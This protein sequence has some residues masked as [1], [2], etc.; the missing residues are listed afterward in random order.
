MTIQRLDELKALQ[1]AGA[2]AARVLEAMRR[3]LRPGMTT[4]QVDEIGRELIERHGARSAPQLVYGFPGWSCISLNDEIV[5]GVPGP[6]RLAPGDVVKLDV[7]VEKDGFMADTA[8][9]VQLAPRSSLGARLASCVRAAFRRGLDAARADAPVRRIGRAVE[10]E[11][12][13]H[14]FR[15]VRELSGHGIGRTIHEPPTVPNFDDGESREL[16]REG[17]VITIEPLISA[18]VEATTVDADGW[19]VRTAD[20]SLAAH[21]EHTLVVRRGA[22]LVLT[23]GA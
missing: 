4:A 10:A 23:A 20:A 11:V 13:R 15:V 22:P 2:L 9:T 19:T 17:M 1:A 12:G 6:R 21:Y 14:G 5:H 3:A 18:G 16:L 7:T 8:A